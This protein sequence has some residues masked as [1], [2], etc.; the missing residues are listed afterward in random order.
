[1]IEN[2]ENIKGSGL[3]EFVKNEKTRWTCSE[4][5]STI[6][7]HRGYCYSCGKKKE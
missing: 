2:L 7:V 6:C 3:K 5:G 4:C 1:M